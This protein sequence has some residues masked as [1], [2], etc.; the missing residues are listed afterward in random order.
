MLTNPIEIIIPELSADDKYLFLAPQDFCWIWCQAD[1]K[2]AV[3]AQ[4]EMANEE[5]TA[6]PAR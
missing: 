3:G 5:T 1:H 4:R 2:H 6:Q